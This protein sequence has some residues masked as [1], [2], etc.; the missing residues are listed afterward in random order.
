MVRQ[1]K[2]Q[3]LEHCLALPETRDHAELPF[4]F[5]S[6]GRS[7]E[8]QVFFRRAYFETMV[9]PFF[10]IVNVVPEARGY[11]TALVLQVI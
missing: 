6:V 5:L 11:Q 9:S 1:G 2:G 7:L 8:S 10:K 4:E 3:V